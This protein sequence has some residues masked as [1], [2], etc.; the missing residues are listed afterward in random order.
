MF[1]I[2]SWWTKR[3]AYAA[4]Q[5][6]LLSVSA[7]DGAGSKRQ[8]NAQH[9][10]SAARRRY[11]AAVPARNDTA[12]E[13]RRAAPQLE[14]VMRRRRREPNLSRTRRSV[15]QPILVNTFISTELGA[16]A[17]L[18]VVIVV[19]PSVRNANFLYFVIIHN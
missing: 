2:A 6:A 12:A 1:S 18:F 9:G 10:R 8:G 19:A 5:S 4:V 11:P 7:G 3:S 14:D 17:R 13:R 16:Y 15:I